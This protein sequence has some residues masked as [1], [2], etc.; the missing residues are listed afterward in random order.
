MAFGQVTLSL[1]PL[2]F[3]MLVNPEDRD[4]LLQ[5]VRLNLFLWGGLQNPII[6][7][8]RELPTIWSDR[9]LRPL[10]THEV[11]RG[12]I[13]TFDPDVLVTFGDVEA[14]VASGSDR[15][16]ISASELTEP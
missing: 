11:I 2:K 7:V 3:E 12:Y 8:Y 5:A 4:A 15:K 13:R 16:V 1:R 9:P 14:T 10:S 6:P